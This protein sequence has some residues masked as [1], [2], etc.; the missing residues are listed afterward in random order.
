MPIVIP[1]GHAQVVLNWSSEIFDSGGAATV[2]GYRAES[3]TLDVDLLA[4]LVGDATVGHILPAASEQLTLVS[5]YAASAT[6]STEV[7]VNS[8]GV[9]SLVMPP[10]NVTLLT[11]KVSTAKGRR[12]RG[13]SYWPLLL[14]EA[15]VTDEGIIDTTSRTAWQAIFQDWGDQI[16]LG[17]YEQVIL[18]STY[19]EQTTPPITPPPTVAS[20]IVD[21]KVATQRRRL[22]R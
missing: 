15:D 8:G 10:P 1:P 13:R 9:Q 12:G 4:G 6:E 16:S 21:A 14:G 19:P 7:A 3:V 5:V 17:G 18:Q 2:L 20:Y 22:R 11:R